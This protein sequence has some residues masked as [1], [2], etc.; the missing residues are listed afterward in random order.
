MLKNST[1]K[2]KFDGVLGIGGYDGSILASAG[3][4]E[5]P[6]E[7]PKLLLSAMACGD[8]KFGEYV[9]ARGITIM[10]SVYDIVGVNSLTCKVF[11]NALTMFGQTNPCGSYAKRMLEE[12]GFNVV[13]FHPNRVGGAA[14]EEMVNEG[15]FCDVWDLTTQEISEEAAF[16]IQPARSGML[17]KGSSGAIPRVVVPGSMTLVLPL[18][19]LSKFDKEG[20]DFYDPEKDRLLFEVLKS[21]LDPGVKLVEV[22][23]HINDPEFAKVCVMNLIELFPSD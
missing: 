6:V 22:D 15:A 14:M 3:M 17:V 7:F 11:D 4:R 20:E 12:E 8:I 21:K 16:G 23:A 19:G 13:A 9:G 18:R 5:L 1:K 10:P 2:K